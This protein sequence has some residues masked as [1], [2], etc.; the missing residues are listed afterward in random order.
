MISATY[1]LLTVLGSVGM[2]PTHHTM[3]IVC[4]RRRPFN[5]LLTLSADAIGNDTIR[6]TG[7]REQSANTANSIVLCCQTQLLGLQLLFLYFYLQH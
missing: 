1:Y 6:P 4:R 5:A 7:G 2:Q 3:S